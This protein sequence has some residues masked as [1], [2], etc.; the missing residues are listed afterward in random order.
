MRGE[1]P[2][3]YLRPLTSK[4][5]PRKFAVLDLETTATL[6]KAYLLGFYDGQNFRHWD[7]LKSNKKGSYSQPYFPEDVRGCVSQFLTWFFE[8]DT[9]CKHWI[10]A[11]NG[12]N[13]DFLYI[14]QW[15][16]HHSDQFSFQVIPLQSSIL[17]L[18]V[19]DKTRSD[20]YKWTFLDSFRLMNASLEKLG[21]A[22]VG[23]GKTTKLHANGDVVNENNFTDVNKYY[24]E[25]FRNPQ[26]YAYLQQDCMLLYRCL[27]TFYNEV[28]QQGGDIG[29]TAPST[30]MKLF[31]RVYL[32]KW[33]PTTL[34]FPG[35][36]CNA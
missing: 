14:V 10:Y 28:Y 1:Q 17:C 35:C 12:G 2:Q 33:V 27:D 9:Y 13:F 5:K 11:H 19:R 7:V 20:K 34:H 22:F 18:T 23:E 36:G 15:L 6:E 29:M 32:K 21:H 26:R 16:L 8:R 24:K 31:R 3:H 4:V 30:S 25:L